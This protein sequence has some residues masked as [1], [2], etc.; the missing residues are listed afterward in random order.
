MNSEKVHLNSTSKVEYGLVAVELNQTEYST[1]SPNI[2]SSSKKIWVRSFQVLAAVGFVC[3]VAILT[4]RSQDGSPASISLQATA[5]EG[6]GSSNFVDLDSKQGRIRGYIR[7]TRDGRDYIA[8]YKIP[9]AQ[10]PVEDLRFQ[11]PKA[12]GSWTGLRDVKDVAPQ[13]LQRVKYSAVVEAGGEEDCLYLN[14]YTPS[15]QNQSVFPTMV[16]I[17]GG[18]FTDGNGSRYGAE[19]FLDEDVVLITIQY[20]LAALGFLNSEDGVFPGNVGFKDQVMALKWVRDNVAEFGGDPNRVTIFGNSAGAMSV[21]FHMVSPLSTGLFHRA[22]TQSGANLCSTFDLFAEN[23]LE[24]LRDVAEELNCNRDGTTTEI[25]DCFRSKPASEIAIARPSSSSAINFYVASVDPQSPTVFLPETPYKISSSKKANPVPYII[26]VLTAEW[27][28]KALGIL[29]DSESLQ[30]LNDEW[31]TQ[32]A[33][34][35]IMNDMTDQE[36]D[37]V[38]TF[39]FGDKKVGNETIKNLTNLE[40]DRELCHCSYLSAVMHA[41][42]ANTYLYYLSKT[43]AKSYAEKAD[44]NFNASS[45]GF[46]AHADELQFQFP[47]YGYP[48]IQKDDPVY[49]SFSK[50]FVRLWAYFAETGN[51]SGMDGLEWS[52]TSSRENAFWFELNDN[53]GR[54]HVL[55]ERMRFWDQFPD[56]RL[57]YK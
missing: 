8:F 22:I 1:G 32:A 18:G 26:G 2:S 40:S 43:P 12:A 54:T 6:S 50:Y 27:V 28:S 42:S 21:S 57:S 36:I 33:E 37:S 7:N 5:E 35:W 44:P 49:Y 45:Y 10:P 3:V 30:K 17:H 23:P 31:T 29:G 55:D 11:E 13:C 48:E 25:L 38:K 46:L 24:L 9:Y 34:R 16:Y 47:Y 20:R 53:P 15:I 41:E 19:Y 14:V 51:P 39:Y 4:F 52:R 56:N